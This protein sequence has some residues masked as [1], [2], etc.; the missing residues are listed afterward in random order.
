MKQQQ[1][2]TTS[3]AHR[4]DNIHNWATTTTTQPSC[5]GL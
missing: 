3:T 4:D 1:T 2:R 5:Y